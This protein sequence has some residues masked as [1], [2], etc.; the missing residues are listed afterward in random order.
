MQLR[1]VLDATP[2]LEIVWVMAASQINDRTHC[3]ID[4]G[5]LRDR[6]HFLADPDSAAMTRLGI[7]KA[8]PEPIEQGVPHPATY[9]A[10]RDGVIR[11]ADVREDFH[12]WLDPEVL[13]QELA[14][15]Q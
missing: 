8:D 11:F 9:L 2:D 7:R 6:I 1:Q 10:D 12:I 4:E 15:L 3:F 5:R 13:V 14:L